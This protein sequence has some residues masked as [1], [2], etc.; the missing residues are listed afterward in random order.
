MFKNFAIVK[1]PEGRKADMFSEFYN[2]S[3]FTFEGLDMSDKGNMRALEKLCRSTG[4]TEKDF[5]IYTFTGKDM[6]EFF[7][8]TD[9][10]AYPDDL[11]F[12][13]VPNYHNPMV[14]LQ[15]GAR[16]FDDIVDNNRIRQNGIKYQ[17]EPDFN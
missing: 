2:T 8:L 13:V 17:C 14:K 12:A 6:N 5:V 16:W 7:N 1:V 10:N 9:S 11:T 3:A 15:T 4:Y